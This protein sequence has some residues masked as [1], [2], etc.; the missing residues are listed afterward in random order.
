[1]L[2]QP[3]VAILLH[4]LNG[5]P[6]YSVGTVLAVLAAGLPG[7]T[8]FQL[9]VR[10]LQSMQRARQVFLLYVLDNALTIVLCIMLGRHS[11]AGLTASVSIG[12]SVA[13]AAGLV[14]LA[15]YRVNIMTGIW[16][17]HVRRSLGASVVAS[18]VIAVVYA[19]PTWTHGLL[20]VTRFGASVVLGVIAYGL[21]VVLLR[22][23]LRRARPKSA[24]LDQF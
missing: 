15:R 24:R 20:L 9:C 3:L 7:F 6:H 19:V 22:R 18:A 12:Y 23:R 16:G 17:V 21:V 4:K 2:S 5:A 8:I 14:V 1:V 11:I 10:G 13:A